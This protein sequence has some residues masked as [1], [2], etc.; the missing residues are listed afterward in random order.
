MILTMLA[1]WLGDLS[2][3]YKKHET[4]SSWSYE[5]TKVD[6]VLFVAAVLTAG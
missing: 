5:S 4:P 3:A 1:T 2:H 6:F